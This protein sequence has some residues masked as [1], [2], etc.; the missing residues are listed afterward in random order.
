MHPSGIGPVV[1]L[2]GTI[3]AWRTHS[4]LGAQKPPLV[5][6]LPSHLEV[7]TKNKTKMSLSQMHHNGVRSVTL[8]W[9]QIVAWGHK[10]FL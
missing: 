3:F 9:G 7:N 2:G 4:R 8:V 1:F 6:I 10:N 5:R